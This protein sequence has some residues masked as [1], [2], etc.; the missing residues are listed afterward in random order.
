MF[1]LLGLVSSVLFTI[2]VPA[3]G[4]TAV[5]QS[6]EQAVVEEVDWE[7][8][9][10]EVASLSQEEFDAQF[11]NWEN[12]GKTPLQQYLDSFDLFLETS[13]PQYDM[14]PYVLAE[15]LWFQ[16]AVLPRFQQMKQDGSLDVMME[17]NMTVLPDVEKKVADFFDQLGEGKLPLHPWSDTVFAIFRQLSRDFSASNEIIILSQIPFMLDEANLPN[18][19]SVMIEQVFMPVD[20]SFR[21][22]QLYRGLMDLEY[23]VEQFNAA[24]N[25][26]SSKETEGTASAEGTSEVVSKTDGAPDAEP[27]S[28]EAEAVVTEASELVLLPQIPSIDWEQV[29]LNQPLMYLLAHSTAGKDIYSVLRTYHSGQTHA[30]RCEELYKECS[31]IGV[32]WG[33]DLEQILPNFSATGI[34]A[35][36]KDAFILYCLPEHDLDQIYMDLSCLKA[37][38][39]IYYSRAVAQLQHTASH[40]GSL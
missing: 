2:S 24:E 19:P 28:Q 29:V 11:S 33:F 6:S 7:E 38:A 12:L 34:G 16:V 15:C 39:P 8:L 10:P 31:K 13:L 35:A 18:L 26:G 22:V 9:E 21:N 4:Q 20:I 30:S 23:L 17:M 5:T 37:I 3:F 32:Q 1:P 14:Q 25:Q 36:K 40:G 27:A